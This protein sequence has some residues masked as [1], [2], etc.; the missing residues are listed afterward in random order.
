MT[1]AAET[2]GI[3]QARMSSSRLPGKVLMPV[4]GKPLLAHLLNRLK[5]SKN[6]GLWVVATSNE[7]TDGPV[8]QLCAAESVDCFRGSLDDVLGR[9]YRC[10]ERYGPK[11]VVRVTADCPLHHFAVVDEALRRFGASGADFFGNS[12]P[13][14]HEDGF[15][16]EVFSFAALQQTWHQAR[17]AYDR[18]HVTPAMRRNERLSRKFEK[19]RPG[20]DYKLS[21]D[22]RAEFLA[23][24]SIFEA[25]YPK[26]P[27]FTMDD[28]IHW[29]EANGAKHVKRFIAGDPA[30]AAS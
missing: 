30:V 8:A 16:T 13:P 2:I 28:V 29:V 24:A 7:P 14:M 4:C 21:V 17:Q 5:P 25:L 10:A 3:I 22:T 11:T 1:S 9:Y 6:V 15:D 20:Y 19:L 27:M 18:E 23:V 26:D 12:F